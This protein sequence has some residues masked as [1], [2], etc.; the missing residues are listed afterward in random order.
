[1]AEK[2]EFILSADDQASSKIKTVESSFS[3]I[4][5]TAGASA[6]AF[7][8]IGAAG[9]L[10]VKGMMDASIQAEQ[11]K[12][13]FEVMM[14]SA[15]GADKMI[16]DLTTFAI[17][18]PFELAGIKENAKLLMNFGLAAQDVL[19]TLQMLGDVSGGDKM[20]M[21][22][23][24]LAFAQVSA[25]GKLSGQDLLQMVNAGFNPLQIM[26]EKTGKSMS[27]L[28]DEM[29]KGKI[30]FEQVK[31]AFQDVTGEGGKFHDMMI[32]Q[33][34]TLGGLISNVS[35]S[36][37]QMAIKMGDALLPQAKEVAIWFN[38]IISAV[39]N[40]DPELLG[41]IGR[42]VAV[43]TGFA[44]VAAAVLGLVAMLNPVTIAVGLI[45]AAVAA[46]Y[47]AWETNFGG[48]KDLTGK[49]VQW[50]T[51][52]WQQISAIT[53]ETWNAI[54]AFF[55]DTLDKIWKAIGPVVSDM[56]TTFQEWWD[57]IQKLWEKYGGTITMV[58]KAWIAVLQTAWNVF[59]TAFST[60]FQAAW[61]YF[62]G[63]ISIAL[64]LL[65]G[66]W[67]AAWNDM[68]T[69]F[70]GIWDAIQRNLGGYLDAIGKKLSEWWGD[71]VKW[72]DEKFGKPLTAAW[73]GIWDGLNNILAPI[74]AGIKNTIDGL[75]KSIQWILDA[76]GKLAGAASSIASSAATAIGN[77]NPFKGPK[78][79][80][81][82]VDSN[83][84]YLVGEN[85][86]E[87]LSL[88]N[89]GG[90]ITPNHALG[91]G[92]STIVINMNG[93]ISDK[94]VAMQYAEI[95]FNKFKLSAAAF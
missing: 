85:G 33:S 72:L 21:D 92:G 64:D 40:M 9:T 81:G 62:K 14:G 39:G 70:S 35:D 50:I 54:L 73:K 24:T 89:S 56:W 23:L 74:I 32:K 26:S 51:D 57:K 16:R 68:L 87:L 67:G 41:L 34:K 11:T 69:M 15:E 47:M 36:I 91:G 76:P 31:K 53:T 77:L 61:A 83:S 6:L 8:A 88:G 66:E 43:A 18:T 44:L 29:S 52:H 2:V 94:Q 3:S 22:S 12:V 90:F 65:N 82:P 71:I 42:T 79:A 93:P 55:K 5:Q 30:T 13:A 75:I 20:R 17:N 80:G 7:G 27:A 19:P 25:A 4:Q 37:G 78:A 45:T 59:W 10:A 1:M 46:L 49:M 95:M 38:Q 60:I 84:T 48:I 28:R 86:P 63:I 58:F